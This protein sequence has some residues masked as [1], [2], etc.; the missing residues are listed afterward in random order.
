MIDWFDF[1]ILP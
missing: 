1:V